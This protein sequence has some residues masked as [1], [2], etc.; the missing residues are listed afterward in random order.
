MISEITANTFATI[1]IVVGIFCGIA[2]VLTV[3]ILV[4]SKVCRIDTD[5]KLEQVA[6]GLDAKELE[7]F[8][9]VFRT[10]VERLEKI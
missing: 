3:L 7:T 1:G 2:L 5:E 8:Y 9:S 10:I 4:V 6:S